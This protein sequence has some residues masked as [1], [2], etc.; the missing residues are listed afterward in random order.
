VFN[1]LDVDSGRKTI[2]DGSRVVVCGG[3]LSGCE[4]AL[5]LAMK[6]CDVTIVDMIPVEEFAQGGHDLA[7]SMLLFMLKNNRLD[8]MKERD[9][10]LKEGKVELIGSSLVRSVENGQVVIE[11]KNWKLRT[12]EADYVVEAFGMKKNQEMVDRF[13]ELIPDVYSVGDCAEVKNIMNA[14]FTAYDR[15][16]N[17]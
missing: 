1:V 8:I 9:P 7:R 16:S 4:S 14:N 17:I 2:P 13:F 15:A 6:G 11:D 5:A 12:I 10:E 3:G